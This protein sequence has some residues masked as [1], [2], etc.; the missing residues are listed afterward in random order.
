[1]TRGEVKGGPPCHSHAGPLFPRL[2]VLPLPLHPTVQCKGLSARRPCT[3]SRRHEHPSPW[4][5]A[6]FTKKCLS[7]S[8]V[9]RVAVP[10]LLLKGQQTGGLK[11]QKP[12]PS[13]S[14]PGSPASRTGQGQAPSAAPGAPA[15]LGLWLHHWLVAASLGLCWV[16]TLNLQLPSPLP[17]EDT[18]HWLVG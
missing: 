10:W 1:M 6:C 7:A 2:Q 17:Q 11:Q 5:C 8:P 13:Q 4:G 14:V 12:I 3:S 18:N 16:L 15:P 9:R